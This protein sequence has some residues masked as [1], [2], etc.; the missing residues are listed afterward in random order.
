VGYH[1]KSLVTKFK[2][3]YVAENQTSLYRDSTNAVLGTEPLRPNPIIDD[4]EFR[5]ARLSIGIGDHAYVYGAFGRNHLQVEIEHSNP[6]WLGSD[7]DYTRFE[8]VA[9]ARIQTFFRRRLI[10]NS[11]DIRIVGGTFSGDLPAQR[12]GIVDGGLSAYR[13]T[14]SLRTLAG[15]PYEGEQ[16]AALF[17]E[18]SFRTVPF[19]IIGLTTA[20]RMSYNLI[21]FGGHGRTWVSEDR[22]ATFDPGRRVSDGIHH[23]IGVGL[24]GILGFVRVDA[25]K[26]LDAQGFRV[27]IAAARIF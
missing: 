3:T 4:G 24:S 22:L 5:A 12:F 11:L 17:W 16:W 19:E 13:P 21:L 7:F 26:R 10:P 2:L 25:A 6:D 1:L 8:F 18:H 9:D 14:G 23:E 15:Y 27:S 20:S